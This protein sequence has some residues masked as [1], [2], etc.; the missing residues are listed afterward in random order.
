MISAITKKGTKVNVH[1]IDDVEPNKGGFYCEVYREGNDDNPIDNFV[2][3]AED[4]IDEKITTQLIKDF[5][6]TINEY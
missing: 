6:A 5:I 2:I 1:L 4:I 3:Q